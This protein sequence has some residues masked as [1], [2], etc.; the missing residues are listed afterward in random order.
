MSGNDSLWDLLDEYDAIVRVIS[1]G[2][3]IGELRPPGFPGQWG[4][5]VRARVKPADKDCALAWNVRLDVTREL[6]D[7]GRA[8]AAFLRDHIERAKFTNLDGTRAEAT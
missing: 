4:V 6:L 5:E 3:F 8:M 7:D 2:G 1:P